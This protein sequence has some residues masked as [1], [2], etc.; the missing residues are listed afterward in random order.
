MRFHG[1]QPSVDGCSAVRPAKQPVDEVVCRRRPIYIRVNMGYNI[2]MTKD[3]QDLTED[4]KALYYEAIDCGATHADA[5]E[6]AETE[7][8]TK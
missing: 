2:H 5:M 8:Y 6:A 3:F 1:S 4:Q 7:G